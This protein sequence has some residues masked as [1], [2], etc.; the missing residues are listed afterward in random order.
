MKNTDKLKEIYPLFKEFKTPSG[1]RVVIRQQNGDDDD[2]LSNGVDAFSGEATSKF[3]SGIIIDS[4]FN[5]KGVLT[6]NDVSY[7]RLSDV[8]FLIIASRIY[9]IGQILNFEY[10]WETNEN[11]IEYEE[12]LGLYIWEYEKAFPFKGDDYYKYRIKPI[13]K[14]LIRSF[15]LSTKKEISYEY[16]NQIGERYLMNLAPKDQ[17]KNQE[18]FARNIKLKTPSGYTKL[19]TFKAFSPLEMREIRADLQK[20]DPTLEIFSE[21]EHPTSGQIV[22]FPIVG[23][24]DFFFP[25]GI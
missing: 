6:P 19:E 5:K 7:L 9:S 21:L 11:P 20:H 2:V 13:A 4:D 12:D 1:H 14:E 3:L 8:Y 15:T 17:S 23:T 18:L 10:Q 16:I 24:P 22:P 25:R